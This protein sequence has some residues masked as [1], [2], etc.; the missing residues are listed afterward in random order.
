MYNREEHQ[1]RI[2]DALNAYDEDAQWFAVKDTIDLEVKISPQLL[3]II[4]E[5]GCYGDD[6][7]ANDYAKADAHNRAKD[8]LLNFIRAI[9]ADPEHSF[10]DE[11][12]ATAR[13]Y[14]EEAAG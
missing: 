6:P 8:G 4:I 5:M 9:C 7:S 11:I 3:R 14:E 1:Q 2:Q 13:Y 12:E 10:F